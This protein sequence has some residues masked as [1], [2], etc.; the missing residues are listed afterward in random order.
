MTT[1]FERLDKD[2]VDC[3]YY[4]LSVTSTYTEGNG[5]YRVNLQTDCYEDLIAITH[6]NFRDSDM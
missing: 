5:K 2:Q 4:I 6:I 1:H 3:T